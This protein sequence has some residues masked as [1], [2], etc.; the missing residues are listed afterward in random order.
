MCGV[1]HGSLGAGCGFPPDGVPT[2]KLCYRQTDDTTCV[3]LDIINDGL[4]GGTLLTA[5]W[6]HT[7]ASHQHRLHVRCLLTVLHC[8]LQDTAFPDA[9]KW[10]HEAD[11]DAQLC[12]NDL[13][14]IEAHNSEPLIRIIKEHLWAHGAPIDCIGIQV[15]P[16]FVYLCLGGCRRL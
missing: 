2:A 7:N 8:W 11:P 9:F 12:I 16:D 3:E 10:A 15:R 4:T 6:L 13:S 5:I 1:Q 14:L